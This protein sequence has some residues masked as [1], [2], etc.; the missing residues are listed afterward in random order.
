[1]TDFR[2]RFEIRE[3]IDERRVYRYVASARTYYDACLTADAALTALG[4]AWVV[5]DSR[6]GHRVLYDSR[7]KTSGANPEG[8]AP[9]AGWRPR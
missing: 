2:D 4:G 1:M 8:N 7:P 9:D 6:D 3:V 5:V